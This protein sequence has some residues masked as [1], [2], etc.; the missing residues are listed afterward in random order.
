MTVSHI[1]SPSGAP[2]KF[3]NCGLAAQTASTR[4]GS[5]DKLVMT[6]FSLQDRAILIVDELTSAGSSLDSEFQEM[7]FKNVWPSFNN[8]GAAVRAL[9]QLAD[10]GLVIPAFQRIVLALRPSHELAMKYDLAIRDLAR[11]FTRVGRELP[12]LLLVI[13]KEITSEVIKLAVEVGDTLIIE[14]KNLF[15]LEQQNTSPKSRLL[16]FHLFHTC[17]D[18]TCISGGQISEVCVSNNELVALPL[19]RVPRTYL[20]YFLRNISPLRPQP[21]EQI[22]QDISE[23]EF[24]RNILGRNHITRRSLITNFHRIREGLEMA[25]A[26]KLFSVPVD[27]IVRVQEY[28]GRETV[29]AIAGVPKVVHSEDIKKDRPN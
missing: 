15:K 23:R 28:P 29:Y 25:Y 20:D 9:N 4:A 11:P 17:S 22:L 6:Q 1:Y 7:G 24:Y 13:Q 21:A 5:G 2:D 27:E 8:V 18:S 26:N 12:S 3:L 16:E 19:A 10:H 14:R